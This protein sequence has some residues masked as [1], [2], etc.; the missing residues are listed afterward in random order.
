L[1]VGRTSHT[2]DD[3]DDKTKEIPLRP[4][5]SL[6]WP[7]VPEETAYPDPLKRDDPKPLQ[8]AQHEAIATSP[9]VRAALEANPK[10]K[11]VLRT[12]DGLEGSARE[13]ALQ[14]SLGISRSDV[15]WDDGSRSSGKGG[16]IV[17]EGEVREAMRGLAE[18]IE[19]AVRGSREGILGLDWS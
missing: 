8:T 1:G 17:S 12:I 14:A 4:L 9:A 11:E 2:G 6:K 7:F 3:I 13:E 10:L 16:E 19:A 18:A 5:T 15:R